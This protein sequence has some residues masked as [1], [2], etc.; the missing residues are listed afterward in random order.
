MSKKIVEEV[1]ANS[2][3]GGGVP[4]IT[5]ATTNYAKQKD[6]YKKVLKRQISGNK[7]TTNKSV[8]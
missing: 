6:K 1:P 8:S 5:D 2:V 3:A 4:S 7:R